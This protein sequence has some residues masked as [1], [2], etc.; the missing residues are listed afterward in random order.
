MISFS[1]NF[2]G[3]DPELVSLNITVL[4]SLR[5]RS[6]TLETT[7]ITITKHFF[8]NLIIN[9]PIFGALYFNSIFRCI[10]KAYKRKVA[11]LFRIE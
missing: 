10:I 4:V 3:T 9:G 7:C 1:E 2:S 11:L 5:S 6:E 8:L